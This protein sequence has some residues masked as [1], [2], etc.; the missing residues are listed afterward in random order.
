MRCEVRE[1]ERAYLL[2]QNTVTLLCV[3]VGPVRGP[4]VLN[5]ELLYTMETV[6]CYM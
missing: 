5:L 4:L 2:F 1:R 3:S 6:T